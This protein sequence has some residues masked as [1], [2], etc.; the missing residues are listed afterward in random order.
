MSRILGALGRTLITLGVLLLLFV[1]FQ[2]W[3]TGLEESSHQSD[4]GGEL[5][6]RVPEVKAKVADSSNAGATAQQLQTIDP[7]A[8]PTIAPPAEGQALG[9][10][11]IAKIGLEKF[12]VEGTAKPD[13]KK[14]PGH[15]LGTPLPGQAGNAAIAGHR[16]TYGAPFNRIDELV[17]GDRIET[18]TSQGKFTYEV[19]APPEAGIHS[20]PGWYTVKATQSSVLDNTPDN[21]LTL[22][23]CHPKYS[24]KERIIVTAKLVSNAAPTT[25]SAQP[26]TVTSTGKLDQAA[27]LE[28]SVGGDSNALVPAI[29]LGLGAALIWLLAWLLTKKVPKAWGYLLGTPA[30]LVMLWFCFLYI[31]RWLPSI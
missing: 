3:G 12:I 17:P 24:A 4:L 13:L 23:A 25:K 7:Q 19:M 2:L 9:V 11:K 5:S 30:F 18:Y 29:L 26:T 16:T 14:G 1:G 27:A 31:D 10:I 20:G 15:Y 21:R 28:A 22:S 8:A 6:S